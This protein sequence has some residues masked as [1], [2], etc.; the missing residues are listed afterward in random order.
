M[1]ARKI[2]SINDKNSAN[3]RT[4]NHLSSVNLASA[5]RQRVHLTFVT[6]DLI[7]CPTLEYEGKGNWFG[8]NERKE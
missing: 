2:F 1:K 7:G 5:D 4:Q 3:N 8:R 6:F